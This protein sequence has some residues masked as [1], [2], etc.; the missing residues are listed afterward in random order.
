MAEDTA[1]K[2]NRE[3]DDSVGKVY[4]T[5]L[6]IRLAGYLRPYLWQSALTAVTV[7]MRSGLEIVGPFLTQ[8][9]VDRYMTDNPAARDTW[10]AHRLSSNPI[11]GITQLGGLYLLSLVLCYG[12]QFVQTYT[13]QWTGQRVMFDMRTQIFRR[14]QQ[15]HIAFFDRNP[16]G[17]LVTRL[18]SDVDAINE[19]FT[20]GIFDIFEDLFVLIGI[21]TLLC[22]KKWWLALLLLTVMPLILLATNIFRNHVRQGYRRIRTAI[23][24]IN[25]FTQEHV[26]GMQVVQLFNRQ[27]KAFHDFDAVNR[28]HMIAFKDT[29]LGYALYYPVVE[30]LSALGIAMILWRGGIGVLHGTVTI[31]VLA[32]FIQYTQ[33]LFR[34]IQSL[35]ERF[36]VLQSAMAACERIFKLLDTEPAVVSPPVPLK[37]DGSN[38]IEFRNVWFTYQE[39]TPE[40]EALIAIANEADLAAMSDVEWILRGVSFLVEPGQTAA[41]VG[42][43]G[44]GKT[45]ITGLMMRFYDVQRGSIL[46]DGVDVRE[47]DIPA[48]RRHFA[49]VL[50]DPVLFSGTIA[51]N[52][53]MG[54]PH[55]TDDIL[56]RAAEDVNVLDYIESLPEGFA[57]PVRER[58]NSFSTGQ[59]QLLNFA[60]A[61]AHNP[62]ILILDEATSSVDTETELRVRK[63]LERMIAGRTSVVI[64][65]R[66]STVQRAN[67]ILVMHKGQLREV[68]THQELLAMHGIYWK[69]YQLQYKDQEL[70]GSAT[71]SLLATGD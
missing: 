30:L 46:V 59:K 71:D 10:M 62:R 11:T 35:S 34:P 66:L 55:L 40:Q 52:L 63:A 16:V 57:A 43:T 19:L 69:L 67:V 21:I 60:R 42:H 47:Q 68:G 38:R 48:L 6:V 7:F 20:A 50:Q 26:S 32:M 56:R 28:E 12:L 37:G 2:Q 44:A 51:E 13:M 53:R 5:R 36:N 23:A 24:K 4:D 33:R 39:L 1:K 41:I 65:H 58:G 70:A 54:T 14:L 31:G 45:T 17:R 18:T 27:Q 9:A 61:L 29:I 49:V 15:L 22:W 8:I 3:K 64:A 25:S